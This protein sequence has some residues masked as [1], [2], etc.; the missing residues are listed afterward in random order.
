MYYSGICM[1]GCNSSPLSWRRH[2]CNSRHGHP[3]KTPIGWSSTSSNVGHTVVSDFS[4]CRIIECSDISKYRTF[5][6]IEISNF[7]YRIER[8]L[9]SIPYI[10][11]AS[12]YFWCW[13]AGAYSER[14]QINVHT[15]YRR[16]KSHRWHS[17]FLFVGYRIELHSRSKI[18]SSTKKNK[19]AL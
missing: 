17:I 13:Y 18:S 14:E 11:G 3:G 9:P 2:T 7:R 19:Q 5:R 16:S 12:R 15:W 4:I 6:H 10:P 1:K 8:V